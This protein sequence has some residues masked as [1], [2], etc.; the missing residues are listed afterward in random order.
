MKNVKINIEVD[1]KVSEELKKKIMSD[2]D[3]LMKFVR[4]NIF[5]NNEK[6]LVSES[7]KEIEKN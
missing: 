6:Y 2:K 3:E 1:L 7:I 5:R 4:N